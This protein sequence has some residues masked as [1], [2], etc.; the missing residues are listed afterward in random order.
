VSKRMCVRGARAYG[1]GGAAHDLGGGHGLGGL[2]HGHGVV[3]G[4]GAG[5][6]PEEQQSEALVLHPWI[7]VA[8]VVVLGGV[9]R[10]VASTSE[11]PWALKY[12]PAAP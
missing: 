12:W 8:W 10:C 11:H 9:L 5:Q 7:R 1:G 6:Q 3:L 4:E 2:G